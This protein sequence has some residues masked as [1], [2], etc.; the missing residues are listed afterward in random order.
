MQENFSERCCSIPAREP[1]EG[2]GQPNAR[3]FRDFLALRG[4]VVDASMDAA[5]LALNGSHPTF[6]LVDAFFQFSNIILGR[7][8]L[9]DENERFE[10]IL[11]VVVHAGIVARRWGKQGRRPLFMQKI[12]RHGTLAA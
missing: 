5:N 12:T 9:L 4:F 6:E 3:G 8:A 2:S 10:D 1:A 11:R 7:H